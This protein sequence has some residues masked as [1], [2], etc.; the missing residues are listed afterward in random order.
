MSER[1]MWLYL[2][3]FFF[4]QK[5]AYEMRIS[6]W[7]SDVCSS[8]LTWAATIVSISH[9]VGLTLPGM[10]ELPGSF[11]GSLS[12]PRPQR[13]P[14]PIRRISLAILVSDTASVLSAAD[15]WTRTSFEARASTLLPALSKGRPVSFATSAAKASPTPAGALLGSSVG[16]VGKGRGWR[17]RRGRSGGEDVGRGQGF[18]VVSRALER[19]AGQLRYCRREGCAEPRRRVEPSADRCPSLRQLGHAVI[20]GA[21]DALPCREELGGITGKFLA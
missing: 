2:M 20:G 7:S 9:C 10:I 3:Y 21:L 14:E 8:D 16:G 15:R 4:K 13:G 1:V 19:E 18:E 17:A 12:S 6:D 5:T 11:S